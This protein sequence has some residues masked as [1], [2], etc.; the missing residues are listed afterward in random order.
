[1]KSL[2][3]LAAAASIAIAIAATTAP[4]N[5]QFANQSQGLVAPGTGESGPVTGPI[6]STPSPY[7]VQQVFPACQI[8]RQQFSDEWGWRVRS[9]L[10]CNPP[11]QQ[12]SGM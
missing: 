5:A 10:V 2:D 6:S 9:V 1:M 11:V 4:G 8:R 12:N 7:V 3:V